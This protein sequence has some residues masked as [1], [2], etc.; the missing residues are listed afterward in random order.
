MDERV[1]S[2]DIARVAG[3]DVPFGDP[4][5]D[6][7][8]VVE[9][10]EIGFVAW[11]G[12][13]QMQPFGGEHFEVIR[14]AYR[15]S[16][17][18]RFRGDFQILYISSGRMVTR[19]A[20]PQNLGRVGIGYIPRCYTVQY[21]NLPEG[22][23]LGWII[24]QWRTKNTRRFTYYNIKTRKSQ[25]NSTPNYPSVSTRSGLRTEPFS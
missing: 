16:L 15:V 4:W 6:K 11:F 20:L 7:F 19:I 13:S 17:S 23:G 5:C 3:D 12:C 14:Y 18:C 9:R 2:I 1:D 8:V 10:Q 25:I 21:Q 24:Q 22:K